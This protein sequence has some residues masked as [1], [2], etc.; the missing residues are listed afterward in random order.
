MDIELDRARGS[1][2]DGACKRRPEGGVILADGVQDRSSVVLERYRWFVAEERGEG[3]QLVEPGVEWIGLLLF[4][5]ALVAVVLV[6]VDEPVEAEQKF[7]AV[8]PF[9]LVKGLA[10][11]WVVLGDGRC[12]RNRITHQDRPAERVG[13][14]QRAI[15]RR[16]AQ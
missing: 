16:G 8:E 6:E 3:C 15:R 11:E 9:Y 2:G 7:V 10:A 1:V 5:R 4:G 13:C 14:L 12:R